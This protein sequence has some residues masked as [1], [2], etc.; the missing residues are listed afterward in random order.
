MIHSRLCNVDLGHAVDPACQ[1]RRAHPED[2]E[3]FFSNV[4]FTN[5]DKMARA[6][7]KNNLDAALRRIHER[8]CTLR[9][10]L[11][12]LKPR[13]VW[14]PTGPSYD[15]NLKKVL[16]GFK[17]EDLGHPRMARVHGLEDLLVP[18]V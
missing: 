5:L 2:A 8:H 3:H 14:F 6:R 10:E 15:E 4:A 9:Q 11:E 1:K 18:G 17:T 16:P 13:L 7:P 12:I